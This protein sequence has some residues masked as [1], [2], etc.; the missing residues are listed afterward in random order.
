MDIILQ[1]MKDQDFTNALQYGKLYEAKAKEYFEYD[2]YEH[3]EGKVSEYD[4]I[5][6]KD[7]VE[8]KVEV[9]ADRQAWKHGNICIE[10][11]SNNTPSGLSITEA[12]YWLYF[13]VSQDGTN[14]EV[15]KIPVDHLKSIVEA[16][17]HN[18]RMVGYNKL[19]KCCLIPKD[20]FKQYKL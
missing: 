10:I 9:K 18:A 6:K 14:D 8:M 16:Y 2:E 3:P 15:Y 19:S 7:N 5:F 20:V 11:E 4:I 17:K 12:H 1:N 13:I